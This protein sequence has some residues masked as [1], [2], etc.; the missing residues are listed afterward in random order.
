MAYTLDYNR[1]LKIV[2][3]V[4]TGPYTAAESRESTSRAIA[5][6]KEHGDANALVDATEAELA[7]SIVDLL[8]L[9]DTQYNAQ[10]MS[11]KIRV[12]V[13]PPRKPESEEDARFYET[14]CLNRGWQVRLFTSRD[15]AIEWLTETDSSNKPDAGDGK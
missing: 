4:Y 8:D 3:L 12:A 7:I 13:L 5:L 11:R 1:T 9:P 15:D 6:G 2:E 10:D 14:A